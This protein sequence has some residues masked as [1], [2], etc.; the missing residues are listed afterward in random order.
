MLVGITGGIG[1][2]KTT[3]SKMFSEF[4]N[5]QIY[6]ADEEAK[7]LMNTSEIIKRKIIKEFSQEAYNE[8]GLN[9]SFLAKIVFESKERLKVLNSIV[10]PEV[11]KH[12][13]GFIA[14]HNKKDYILYENAILFENGSHKLCDKIITVS[15]P[16]DIRVK[17]VMKRD[18]VDKETVLNRVKNQWSDTKKTI[19]SHYL[20][21]NLD[22]TN[23][24]FDVKRIHNKLTY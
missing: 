6:H 4:E 22:L 2:G 1:S 23:V 18:G 10:H 5:V 17:R 7:R 3:V 24:W 16:Q 19:Q 14:K 21:I 8:E 13:Q 15:V 9:R 12:L 11:H 20:I